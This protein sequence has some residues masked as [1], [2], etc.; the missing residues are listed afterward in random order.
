MGHSEHD[1]AMKRRANR[2]GARRETVCAE[3]RS[4]MDKNAVYCKQACRQSLPGVTERMLSRGARSH[5]ACR[6]ALHCC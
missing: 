6:L 4:R 1:E 2:I 3:I 5:L